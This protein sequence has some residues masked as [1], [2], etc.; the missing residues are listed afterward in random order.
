M[1]LASRTSACRL[2]AK[3]AYGHR[4]HGP[5]STGGYTLPLFRGRSKVRSHLSSAGAQTPFRPPFVATL[6][7][8]HAPPF[9]FLSRA[10][11]LRHGR[12]NARLAAAA[13]TIPLL[14]RERKEPL[15][16]PPHSL[17]RRK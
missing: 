14:A 15:L 10:A 1:K 16:G 2:A 6:H 3:V 12:R 17:Q 8:I 13:A 9:F 5:T 7:F 11:R 4:W